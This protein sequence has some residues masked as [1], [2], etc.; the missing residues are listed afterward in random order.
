MSRVDL[1]TNVEATTNEPSVEPEEYTYKQM[2]DKVTLDTY[3]MY[4][5]KYEQFNRQVNDYL[6]NRKLPEHLTQI[7]NNSSSSEVFDNLDQSETSYRPKK[8]ER[9]F[10]ESPIKVLDNIENK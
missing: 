1:T 4:I 9:Q 8:S 10:K 3:D 6:Q 7:L 2:N 5:K